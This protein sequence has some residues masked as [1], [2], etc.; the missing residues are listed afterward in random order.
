MSYSLT[1]RYT[2]FVTFFSAK[3]WEEYEKE[4]S[5]EAAKDLDGTSSCE[6]AEVCLEVSLSGLVCGC[7]RSLS[8][9]NQKPDFSG[10]LFKAKIHNGLAKLK[11]E[12]FEAS[13]K[14]FIQVLPV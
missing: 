5:I 6:A 3:V 2:R 11:S 1:R 9:A 4:A 12:P 7:R 14:C 8:T 10:T 13:S